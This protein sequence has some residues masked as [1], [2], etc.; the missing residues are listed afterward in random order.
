[1]ECGHFCHP[2][3]PQIW[4]WSLYEVLRKHAPPGRPLSLQHAIKR[5][6]EALMHQLAVDNVPTD[7]ITQ[8]S[9]SRHQPPHGREH[10]NLHVDIE[11]RNGG[12]Y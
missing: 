7:V 1:M 2:S 6:E 9:S 12:P 11:V 3:A 4:V 8:G 10:M 5:E